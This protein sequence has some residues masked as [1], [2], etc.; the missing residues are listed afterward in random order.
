VL[1]PPPDESEDPGR[2]AA[3]VQCHNGPNF[4]DSRFHR[5]GVRQNAKG[6]QDLGR[7]AVSGKEEPS[8]IL[9]ARTKVLKVTR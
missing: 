7:F 2:Q 6:R 5:L 8:T 9:S 4:M 3:C 1:D